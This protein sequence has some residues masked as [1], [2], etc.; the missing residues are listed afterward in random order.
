MGRSGPLMLRQHNGPC[1][2]DLGAYARGLGDGGSVYMLSV[3]SRVDLGK[4]PER[5]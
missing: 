3:K 2:D 4:A 5:L 1:H